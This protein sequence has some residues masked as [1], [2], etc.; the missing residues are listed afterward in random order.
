MP[1]V[2][3]RP[4]TILLVEEE[5]EQRDAVTEILAGAESPRIDVEEAETLAAGLERL[6]R[7]GID[8]VLLDLDLPDSEGIVTFE[9]ASAFA[10]DVPVVVLTD[11]DDE[12]VAMGTVQGGA[13]DYLVKGEVEA[14]L[15]LRSVRYAVERHRLLSALRS[16]S[17]IDDLT[18]L[19]NQRG[20]EELGTQQ[21][22]LARRMS[23]GVLLVVLDVDRFKTI[24]DTLGHHVGDRALLKLAELV[25]S[26]FR[27]SDLAARMGGDDFAI[28]A[29]EASEDDAKLITRRIRDRIEHFNRTSKEPYRLSLSLGVARY[30]PEDPVSLDVLREKART[31]IQEEKD[32]K[33][34]AVA[35]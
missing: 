2:D 25:R 30:D 31:A 5:S 15:L 24:N 3:Q 10:P 18:G 22:K 1:E 4:L 32:D 20:F 23:R 19:Y 26:T 11:V 35:P 6:S 14:N 28:L 34:R 7:G 8:L 16:L 13:Q 9:R 21:L 33:R 29:M 27:R 17:L 12:D